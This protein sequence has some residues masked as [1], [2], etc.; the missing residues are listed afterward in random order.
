MVLISIQQLKNK[1]LIYFISSLKIIHFQMETK[2]LV[3]FFSYGFL[4]K[5]IICLKIMEKIKSM[6]MP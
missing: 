2:E 3:R 4:T 1:R 5:T 6:K